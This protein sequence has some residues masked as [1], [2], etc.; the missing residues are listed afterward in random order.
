M[1]NLD[2]LIMKLNYLT[3]RLSPSKTNLQSHSLVIIEKAKKVS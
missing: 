3:Q 1:K 2:D